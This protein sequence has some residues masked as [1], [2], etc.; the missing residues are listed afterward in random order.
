MKLRNR[1]YQF[2][3]GRNGVDALARF[4][5]IAGLSFLL[6]ALLFTILST[7]FWRHGMQG[8]ATVFTVLHYVFYGIGL[9]LMILW[10]FRI[11]SRNVAKRQAENTRFLYSRQKICRKCS[12]LKQ[13]WKERKTYR[14]FKCPNCRQQMR[15]PRG[16]GKIRVTCRNCSHIFETKT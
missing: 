14:Y 12:V 1:I 2:M 6:T 9:I 10:I 5:N 16:K 7:A 4:I 13:R 3:Q 8:P 15:A 11:L